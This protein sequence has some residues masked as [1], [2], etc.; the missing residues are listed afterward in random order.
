[1]TAAACSSAAAVL[2]FLI[3]R[4]TGESGSA[5]CRRAD[6]LHRAFLLALGA[7]LGFGVYAMH[8]N[9]TLRYAEEWDGAEQTL[10][11]RVMEAPQEYAYYTRIH[12][13]RTEAPKLD[14]MLYD[15]R[16]LLP[17]GKADSETGSGSPAGAGENT[18]AEAAAGIEPGMLL[19]VA[20]KLR[21]ADLR[22]GERNDSY[23]SK[24][25]YLTGTL[26]SVEV[27]PG[28]SLTLRTLAARC[29]SRISAFAGGF[30]SRDTSVFL[31]SL[32]LGDKTDFYRDIPLYASMR[33]AGF[34]HIVAV[35]GVQYLIF[36][37]YRIARKPVNWALFGTRPLK[38]TRKLHFT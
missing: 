6:L 34:M 31:R 23:V 9:R 7:A 4:C 5:S 38:C 13:Q 11:V 28:R 18:A 29:S 15:Y 27:L 37:F 22:Y 14:I 17:G 33:G 1:M 2:L 3:W 35:S 21:R 10:S 12:V 26:R 19:R 16:G 36:G 25:I 24:D 20:A 30:F 8:W 32:M